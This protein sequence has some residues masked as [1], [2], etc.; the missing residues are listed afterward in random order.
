[1]IA[2]TTVQVAW[3]IEECEECVHYLSDQLTR[4][5]YTNVYSGD[6]VHFVNRA[7]KEC[8]PDVIFVNIGL[9]KDGDFSGYVKYLYPDIPVVVLCEQDELLYALEA[10]GSKADHYLI[11]GKG[12]KDAIEKAIR[13]ASCRISNP[14]LHHEY[15]TW[16]HTLIPQAILD[17]ANVM[18]F[19]N[20]EDPDS[21]M[22]S[23]VRNAVTR[24]FEDLDAEI[25][26]RL[27][28]V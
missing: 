25:G 14:V 9:L 11:R 24:V 10:I 5:H 1:M 19:V 15:V 26:K 12:L 20:Y 27:L 18:F 2:T 3:I 4:L 17:V 28:N 8:P 21:Q 22:N 16:F 13:F 6:E 7:D 23:Q